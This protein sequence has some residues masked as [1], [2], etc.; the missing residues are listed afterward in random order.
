MNRKYGLAAT[1][2]ML[3]SGLLLDGGLTA[4][5]QVL[6]T[7]PANNV[8]TAWQSAEGNSDNPATGATRSRAQASHAVYERLTPSKFSRRVQPIGHEEETSAKKAPRLLSDFLRNADKPISDNTEQPASNGPLSAGH[9]ILG[10]N[11]SS[12]RPSTNATS[13]PPLSRPDSRSAIQPAGLDE[14]SPASQPNSQNGFA[15]SP[16]QQQLE[17]MYRRD[18]RPVPPLN[19]QQSQIN[20]APQPPTARSQFQTPGSSPAVMPK[21]QI[22]RPTPMPS[23]GP[24]N[25]NVVSPNSKISRTGGLL[26]R[27]N[28]FKSRSTATPTQPPESAPTQMGAAVKPASDPQRMQPQSTLAPKGFRIGGSTQPKQMTSQPAVAAPIILPQV[29]PA[30]NANVAPRSELSNT[31]PPVPG[32]PGFQATAIQV[33]PAGSVDDALDNV[34]T[35]MEEDAADGKPVDDRKADD[36]QKDS[37]PFSGLS[38]DSQPSI[39]PEPQAAETTVSTGSTTNRDAENDST[40]AAEKQDIP[41]PSDTSD[42]E[43]SKKTTDAKRKLIAERTDLQGMKGFCPVALRDDRDLQNALPEH[44]SLF[45]GRTYYFS[46]A[47]AKA[48]FD[49][50]PEQYA[51]MA[52]GNDV[53]LLKTKD[54]KEGSLDFAVWYKDR[55]YLFTSQKTLEQFIA[56]PSEFVIKD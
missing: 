44:A 45:K 17:D 11:T 36:S 42:E 46:S 29:S 15:P 3:G 12:N 4:E 6:S 40:A 26:N 41:L 54:T 33:K 1:V 27:I 19:F 8:K 48:T 20:A 34:F 5:A 16:I 14:A 53:V 39:L 18:G 2:W 43:A 38:L 22:Q 7:Q 25:P 21:G 35:E 37:S 52:C 10:S 49:E 56:T 47:D 51:P 9:K 23:M 30:A 13:P 50:Q 31:L 32:D 28:P 24:P 55:L